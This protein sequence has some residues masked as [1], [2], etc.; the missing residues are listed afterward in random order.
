MN[1]PHTT[2][3]DS[4]VSG[5]APNLCSLNFYVDLDFIKLSHFYFRK[6]IYSI[7]L[8]LLQ[9][10][11]YNIFTKKEC[12]IIQ[13]CIAYAVFAITNVTKN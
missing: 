4:E 7:L 6:F 3:H 8:Q 12:Q 9:K 10:I 1:F 2:T 13:T 5:E 11:L